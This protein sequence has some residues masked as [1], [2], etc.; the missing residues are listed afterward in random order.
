MLCEVLQLIKY[1]LCAV[2]AA[3]F[4]TKSY[5]AILLVTISSWITFRAE[6][7][8]VFCLFSVVVSTAVK[9]VVVKG[10]AGVV[11]SGKLVSPA[12]VVEPLLTTAKCKTK[13]WVL[14]NS[15]N[16]QTCTQN[17]LALCLAESAKKL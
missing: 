4:A 9:T 3:A 15:H 2:A 10:V 7:P 12:G 1:C 17:I 5:I 13:I 8:E 16:F 6:L 14:N 11:Q